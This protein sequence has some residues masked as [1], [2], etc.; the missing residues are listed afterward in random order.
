MNELIRSRSELEKLAELLAE[1][2]KNP[3]ENIVSR[4]IRVIG[5]GVKFINGQKSSY[6][7]SNSNINQENMSTGIYTQSDVDDLLSYNVEEVSVAR[8][9]QEHRFP[10]SPKGI[11]LPTEV[12]SFIETIPTEIDF[13]DDELRKFSRE[14]KNSRLSRELI[15]EQKIIVNS[16]GG[17]VIQTI[18]F[19]GV[20][21]SH[22]YNPI[23][24][25]RNISVVCT[26]NEDIRRLPSLIK[27]LADPTSE[28]RI[29]K[30]RTFSEAF[31]ELYKISRLKFGSMEE[32]G[33]P[34]SGLH[35]VVMLTGVPIHEIF[36]H[37]FEEPI[38]FLSFGECGTFRYGQ[39]IKNKS[40]VLQ[41]NPIQEIEGFKVQGFT[42][43]DAYG[44]KRE[45][46][47]HIKDGKVV[48]FLGSEYADHKNFKNYLN[49]ERSGFIGNASQHIDGML[50]QPRM[51]CTVIDGLTEKLDLEGKILLVPNEGHT[52][53]QDKTYMVKSYEV[54]I[55]REGIPK[56]LIPLQVTGGIN[57]AL[58]NLILLDDESYQTGMCGKPEPIYCSQSENIAKVPVSSFAKSQMWKGQ[59]VY[60]LPV[61]DV[62][63][64]ILTK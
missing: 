46:R 33:I 55:V 49:L 45:P 8:D 39:D 50:P 26:T 56:R 13:Y 9:L 2:I 43:I 37:H 44:R 38:R 63:L 19:F 10:F 60:P 40:I 64:K 18:P 54:Y 32:A 21:Y 17:I 29:K 52:Q 41:D 1:E 47:I 61:S 59:Q 16:R 62:H 22:G 11:A 3:N 31:D 35:D 48:G 34:L 7:A 51:S 27:Y 20:S 36:G 12:N 4:Y 30:S 5:D 6:L 28:K 25:Q 24:T 42:Y 53:T 23:Q 15:V 14:H 58:A 57:Q